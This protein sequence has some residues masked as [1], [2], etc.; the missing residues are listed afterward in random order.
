MSKKELTDLSNEE[1]EKFNWYYKIELKKG[2]TT[3]G[4]VR[5]TSSMTRRIVAN[6]GI[7][8]S[9]CLDIGAQEGLLSVL[10]SRHGAAK[11]AAY[12]RLDL[13]DRLALVQEAYGVEIDYYHSL[14][15]NELPAAVEKAGEDPFDVVVFAGVLYHM[16]DPLAGLAL[17]RS[18]IREGGLAVI[19]TSVVAS[20]ELVVHI[21][22]KGR[23]YK[24]SNYFQI[25]LGSLD[26]FLRMLRLEPIDLLFTEPS[27]DNISRATIVARAVDAVVADADDE[28]MKGNWVE[29]DMASTHVHYDQLKSD[30]APVEYTPINPAL[31]FYE[32]TKTVDIM[33]TFEASE[34]HRTTK[35]EGMLR[36][37]DHASRL[38]TKC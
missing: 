19:E 22:A 12:D 36:L 24:G 25:S 35:A 32:G 5:G 27:K 37:D 8:G 38:A 14:Q 18:F 29:N 34:P 9:R 13:A 3:G 26:Y 2:A 30:K 23:Y 7:D 17:T 33:S 16:I 20:G 1:I 11:V 4:R 10:M 31:K 21:N 15:L 6:M 28:W